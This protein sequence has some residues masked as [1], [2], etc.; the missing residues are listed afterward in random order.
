MAALERERDALRAELDQ[1]EER[2]RVM[3]KNH[4]DVCDRI[5]WALDSLHNILQGKG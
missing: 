1:A 4:A 5:A 2:L 3:Q